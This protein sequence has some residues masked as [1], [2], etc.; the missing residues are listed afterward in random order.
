MIEQKGL[1]PLLDRLK[2]LGGWP[3]LDGD[4]WHDKGFEWKQSVYKLKNFRYDADY[5]FD[6]GIGVDMKNS[7]KRSLE[8]RYYSKTHY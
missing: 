4:K 6:F 3:V 1:S 7:T 5:F 8:V 2:L